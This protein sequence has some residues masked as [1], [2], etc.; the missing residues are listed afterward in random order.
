MEKQQ[1]PE[2]RITIEQ[3]KAIVDAI[4]PGVDDEEEDEEEYQYWD[5]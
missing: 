3:A 2:N 4:N 5:E 1:Q